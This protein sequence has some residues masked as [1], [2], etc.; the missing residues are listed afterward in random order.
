MKTVVAAMALLSV[1][2]TGCSAVEDAA[3][4][5]A[6]AATC[7]VVRGVAEQVR[8][9]GRDAASGASLEDLKAQAD[10]LRASADG[11]G[12]AVESLSPEVATTLQQA[13]DT[14]EGAVAS[15][16]SAAAG[17]AADQAIGAA[18]SSYE[19]AVDQAVSSLGC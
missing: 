17:D 16:P 15:V 19:A 4:R 13:A 10:A 7:A 6:D 9:L 12:A 14:F 8:T 18:A 11:L 5:A 3:N 2:L 1:G